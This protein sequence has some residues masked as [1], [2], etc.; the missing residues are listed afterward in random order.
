MPNDSHFTRSVGSSR[1]SVCPGACLIRIEHVPA[2]LRF[3]EPQEDFRPERSPECPRL[4]RPPQNAGRPGVLR[5]AGQRSRRQQR[6]HSTSPA[7]PNSTPSNCSTET[8]NTTSPQHK[9]PATSRNWQQAHAPTCAAARTSPTARKPSSARTKSATQP[10]NLTHLPYGSIQPPT[11]A[12][13]SQRRP[14]WLFRLTATAT[15]VRSAV[16]LDDASPPP[17]PCPGWGR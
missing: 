8:S 7:A 9:A 1:T 14:W 6:A 17:R 12:G 2:I 15:P 4:R 16:P 5:P 3:P 10:N 11:E 13:R